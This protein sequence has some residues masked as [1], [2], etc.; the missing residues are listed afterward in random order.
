MQ[1]AGNKVPNYRETQN[2][3]KTVMQLYAML[4]PP[5]MAGRRPRAQPRAHG[6]AGGRRRGPR[7]PAGGPAAPALPLALAAQAE[8]QD[9]PSND[10]GRAGLT[11]QP[12]ISRAGIPWNKN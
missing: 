12:E 7:Q 1:R 4:K 3:V 11:I 10:A 9:R 5:S 8:T 6:A 2:Y